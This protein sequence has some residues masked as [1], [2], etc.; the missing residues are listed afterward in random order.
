MSAIETMQMA[1]VTMNLLSMA[2]MVY[3]CWMTRKTERMVREM[4]QGRKGVDTDE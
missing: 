4:V 1:S 2:M 3:V